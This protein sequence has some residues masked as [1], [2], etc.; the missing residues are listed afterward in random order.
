MS[1]KDCQDLAPLEQA[2]N[3]G[4]FDD[5]VPA[6]CPLGDVGPVSDRDAKTGR[7]TRGNR[8]ALVVGARSRAFWE[9]HE[10]ARREIVEAVISDAGHD[11]DDA[12]KALQIAAEGIAQATLVRDSAFL[13]VVESGGPMTTSGR[14]RRSFNAWLAALDRLERH[15]RLVG[16]RREPKRRTNSLA[17][18]LRPAETD[19]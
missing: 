1:A 10:S 15:L 12:P 11:L 2:G 14:T 7:F 16:L 8:S 6:L 17:E 3:T 4:T 18:L 19:R 9:V 13:L 5:A